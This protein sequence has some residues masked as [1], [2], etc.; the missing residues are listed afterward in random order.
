M[1]WL[2]LS[3]MAVLGHGCPRVDGGDGGNIQSFSENCE[4]DT[5]ITNI[6]CM[7][8]MSGIGIDDTANHEEA[9]MVSS[10]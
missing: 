7:L 9:G 4:R 5:E 2:V 10:R 1:Q 6:L 3:P 8:T